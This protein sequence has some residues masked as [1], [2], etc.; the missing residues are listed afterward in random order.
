MTI[1][2]KVFQIRKEAFNEQDPVKSPMT[3]FYPGFLF[4][5]FGRVW[6]QRGV[7]GSMILLCLDSE[8]HDISEKRITICGQN[9]LL[10]IKVRL[11]HVIFI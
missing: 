10:L 4:S 2:I 8:P 3:W 6:S 11:E 9:I 7:T 1:A 5:F